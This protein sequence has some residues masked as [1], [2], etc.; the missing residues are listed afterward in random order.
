[1][2]RITKQYETWNRFLFSPAS[3]MSAGV[4]LILIDLKKKKHYVPQSGLYFH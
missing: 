3:S 4:T 1:M 2:I